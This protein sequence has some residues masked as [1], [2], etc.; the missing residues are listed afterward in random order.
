MKN[1]IKMAALAAI[2]MLASCAAPRMSTARERADLNT[3]LTTVQTSLIIAQVTETISPENF[4]LAME[5]LAE[6]RKEIVKSESTA[7]GWADLAIR[8]ANLAARWVIGPMPT[9][10]Q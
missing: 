9:G 8:V 10:P 5:Q 7:I 3:M 2:L 6:I 4:K 1:K